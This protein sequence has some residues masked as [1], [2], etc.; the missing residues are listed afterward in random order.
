M[1]T[2]EKIIVVCFIA[3]AIIVSV[4]AHVFRPLTFS[5]AIGGIKAEE[6]LKLELC[7]DSE[8]IEISSESEIIEIYDKISSVKLNAVVKENSDGCS[9]VIFVYIKNSK[10]CISY[11]CDRNFYKWDGYKK[12]VG[13]FLYYKDSSKTIQGVIEEYFESNKNG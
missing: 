9:F 7:R 10:G 13:D 2:K 12:G 11:G 6:I 3:I 4:V 1:K 5:Q 8:K